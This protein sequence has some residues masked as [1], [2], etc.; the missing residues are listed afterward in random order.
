M[1]EATPMQSF[2]TSLVAEITPAKLWAI[3]TDLLPYI[4]VIVLFA[5]GVYFLRK[6]IKGTAKAKVRL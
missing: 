5:L 1:A 4:G 2:V 6:L 3:F